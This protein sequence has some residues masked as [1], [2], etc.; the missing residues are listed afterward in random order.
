MRIIDS[1]CHVCDIKGFVPSA[2]VLPVACGYSHG[3]N[4]KTVEAAKRLNL[5]Y[6][7][8]IAPQSV[9]KEGTD[10]LDEWIEFIKKSTPNAIGE[11]GLDYHWAKN[12]GDVAK[13]KLAFDK[14]LELADKMKLPI[15]IHSRDATMDV[16][17]TIKEHGFS[18]R[19]V[20]HFYSGNEK[21]ADVAVEMGAL[22]SFP[23]LRSKQRRNI[24][25]K[26][27]LENILVETDAPF[28]CRRP[29]DVAKAI[30][31]VAEV[32]KIDYD[33]VAAQ[34][35]KNAIDFFRIKL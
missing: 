22:L 32:K 10:K 14:M 34:T 19:T 5:P 7:L 31:Y 21:E 16:I 30:E 12:I 6:V 25:N 4:V 27:G 29:E 28:V 17:N 33:V 13:E 1:H 24:I 35:T 9:L 11:I 15:V 2:D 3:S 26:I 20:F 23:P 8:G 18:G